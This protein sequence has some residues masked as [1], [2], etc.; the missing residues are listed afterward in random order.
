MGQRQ[1]KVGGFLKAGIAR[2]ISEIWGG[3][4]DGDFVVK[5]YHYALSSLKEREAFLTSLQPSSEK[6]KAAQGEAIQAAVAIGQAR[7]QMAVALVDAVN[8]QLLGIV[9]AWATCLF[10]GY[11]LLSK[12]HAMSFIALGVGALAVASAI[13]SII[14][15]SD[16]Y[17]GMFRVSAHP[18]I[19]VLKAIDTAA[20]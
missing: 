11:G 7:L 15:L 6:Q 3:G 10:C 9:V 17:S 2:T 20:K 8:Y 1:R 14:D 13:E 18:L 4:Y 16:P 12:R 5:N 19:D